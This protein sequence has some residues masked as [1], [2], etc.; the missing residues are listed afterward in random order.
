MTGSQRPPGNAEATARYQRGLELLRENQAARGV[1]E[2]ER[3]VELDPANAEFHKVLGNARRAAGDLEGAVASYRSSLE[4]APQHIPSRYNLGLVL[5]DLNRPGEAEEQFR[6]IH[7]ADPRDFEVLFQLALLLA[8]RSQWGEAVQMYRSALELAPDDPYLWFHL[9]IAYRQTPG[10]TKTAIECLRKSIGLKPDFTDAHHLM[11]DILDEE[12]RL[13]E[14]VEHYR[15]AIRLSPENARVHGNL[16]DTLLHKHSL[17][18]AIHSYTRAIELAPDLAYAHFNLGFVYGMTGAHDRALRCYETVLRLR[19]DDASARGLLLFEMQRVC[20]WSRLDQL[21]ELQRR[22]AVSQPDKEIHPFGL[23]TIPST[24]AEQLQ[25]ARNYA[26]FRTRAAARDR[27]HLGFR[28]ER[29]SKPQLKVGYLSADFREHPGAYLIAELIELHDRGRFDVIGYSYA[30]DDGSRIRARLLQAFDRFVDVGSLSHADAAARIHAD[31][32]DILVDLTGYTAY[33]RAEIAALRPAPI[34]VNYLGYAGTMGADFADY[35]VTDRFITPPGHEAFF[36]EKPVYLPGSY[37]ANDRKRTVAEATSRAALGLPEAALVFCCFNQTTRILPPVF[38]A[39]MR[40]LKAIPDSVLWLAESNPWA[41][42]N[43]RREARKQ[44]VGPA[45]LVFAPKCPVD[46]F[47]AHLKAADLFLDTFPYNAHT[48][49]SDALWV[50]LPV[51]TCAGDTFASRVAGSLLTAV[52]MPELI[53]RSMEEYE[54]LA[55]RLARHPA[56]LRAL[57]EKLSRNRPSSPLF[58]TP[59][60]ARHLEAAY[61][62]M[63]ENYLAGNGP[64]A[65][66][67]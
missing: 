45:R 37:Q 60:Y 4:I 41:T 40:L 29:R 31:Q 55:L 59:R 51:L 47:R 65:I 23:L 28:F 5:L 61:H 42:Q 18:E 30:R 46:Q 38:A 54:A 34:Q 24:P 10:Q 44:D 7:E 12:H 19:P 39:W 22:S 63:W 1:V 67:I 35:I 33:S 26:A 13:D 17:D 56:E 57:H 36:A 64:R 25:C 62:Q 15:E 58:D 53:T 6:R 32:V 20:D 50:G 27:E 2:L 16:G 3:A 66:G 43:L 9:A 52:G 21:C 11:G 48:T 8:A 14:A 49:A